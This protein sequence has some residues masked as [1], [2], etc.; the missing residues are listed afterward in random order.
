MLR[1]PASAVPVVAALLIGAAVPAAAAAEPAA[2]SVTALTASVY[3]QLRAHD[4]DDVLGL[5]GDT[6]LLALYAGSGSI[7]SVGIEVR[8]FLCGPI[9][10]PVLPTRP[11]CTGVA[12]GRGPLETRERRLD[13]LERDRIRVRA[14]TA[15]GALDITVAGMHGEGP[16]TTRRWRRTVGTHREAG[17]ARAWLYRSPELMTGTF[18]GRPLVQAQ[19]AGH[20]PSMSV[21][22][23]TVA[24]TTVPAV[25]VPV[26]RPPGTVKDDTV[27]VGK[28]WVNW[29]RRLGRGPGGTVDVEA[30]LVIYERRSGPVT[31]VAR[32][33]RQRCAPGQRLRPVAGPVPDDA[34]R[35]IGSPVELS[36]GNAAVDVPHARLHVVADL[37]AAGGWPAAR[38]DATWRGRVPLG[39]REVEIVPEWGARHERS[40]VRWR[41]LTASATVGG[42]P[43]RVWDPNFTVF[44]ER[45]ESLGP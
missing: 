18:G 37:P 40:G 8:N 43:A 7:P 33:L 39:V 19:D 34:C 22:A 45:T 20:A 36:S 9:E 38:V 15:A 32:A 4:A 21:T 6:H 35:P 23:T 25:P 17:H 24:T 11:R 26:M 3:L 5:P 27:T 2:P 29:A 12:D 14:V 10:P 28:G 30:G 13:V 42:R 41:H 44:R 1:R 31:V 16:F